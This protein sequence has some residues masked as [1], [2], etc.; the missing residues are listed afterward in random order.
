M[1]PGSQ[2]YGE[3]ADRY[4]LHTPPHHYRHDHEFVI[5]RI[6]AAGGGRVLDV[7]C[8][9][10]VFLEKALAA[11]LD[12]VGLEPAPAMAVQAVKRV[13]AARVWELPMQALDVR[14]ELDAIV[15][16]SWSM[17][18]CRDE[19]ELVDVLERCGRGLRAGG[20]FVLQLAHA[21]H[22]ASSPPPFMVDRE[23]GPGG[24][25]DIV[26]HYRFWALGAQ[27]MA[28]EYQ[29][30][31]ISS[32]ERFEETHELQVADARRIAEI[33]R[34]VGFSKVEL[35]ED[36]RGQPFER[37]ISPFVVARWVG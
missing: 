15:S 11:G 19:A 5:E 4:D 9:T 7:G 27:T 22:A 30:E 33:A 6:R 12:P 18:Y 2:L 28:A 1:A 35:L 23:P 3:F 37:A 34:G 25:E 32:G 21:P 31:C 10:G 13:G 8:G 20:A 36:H 24:V 14:G 16:L 29:F 17:N 26:L